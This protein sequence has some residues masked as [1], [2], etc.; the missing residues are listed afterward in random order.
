MLFAITRIYVE[1]GTVGA[2]IAT[3]DCSAWGHVSC[4]P[5]SLSYSH[6]L[7]ILWALYLLC[8]H[9][10]YCGKDTQANC[11]LPRSIAILFI[12]TYVLV[13]S[14]LMQSS[15]YINYVSL[16]LIKKY[17]GPSKYTNYTYLDL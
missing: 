14:R 10:Y 16:I 6:V 8:R 7:F 1:T 11:L 3:C 13:C 12:F 2:G 15:Y 4:H 5:H 17:T 9:L